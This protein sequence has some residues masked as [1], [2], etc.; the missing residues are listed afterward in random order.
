MERVKKDC[1]TWH[2]PSYV[3]F[4]CCLNMSRKARHCL[5]R[6]EAGPP[7]NRVG[8]VQLGSFCRSYV[9][10]VS[11]RYVF[12]ITEI[13]SCMAS[14]TTKKHIMPSFGLAIMGRPVQLPGPFYMSR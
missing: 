3:I 1:W 2:Q 6:V 7:P 4:I 13:T 8:M 10:V 9:A 14:S 5:C 12:G 11:I